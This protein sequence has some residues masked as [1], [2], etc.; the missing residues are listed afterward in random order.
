MKNRYILRLVLMLYCTVV[1]SASA[2]DTT[3]F[4]WYVPASTCAISTNGPVHL[5]DVDPVAGLG[6]NW[7]P[8][9]KTPVNI[10]LTCTDG[11]GMGVPSVVA[12]GKTL[13][14]SPFM[15]KTS[16]TSVGFG[17][18]L[19]KLT[20]LSDS[21]DDPNNAEV[22]IGRHL[23]I[24][25]PDGGWLKTGETPAGIYNLPLTAAVTCGRTA[26]CDANKLKAGS[27]KGSVT[28]TFQYK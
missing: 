9:N 14:K 13:D 6:Q 10:Q 12:S 17:F 2:N 3:N 21:S 7:K 8:L 5:G 19:L 16:G 15:F 11:A 20:P 23:Y 28:F 27:L 18:I 24:P 22:Q 4:S 1:L 25:K 26:W